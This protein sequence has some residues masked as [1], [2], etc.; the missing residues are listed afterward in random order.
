MSCGL[1]VLMLEK[2][3]EPTESNFFSKGNFQKTSEEVNS[4]SLVIIQEPPDML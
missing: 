2:G 3:K 1:C 4:S